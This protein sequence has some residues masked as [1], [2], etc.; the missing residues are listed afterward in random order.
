MGSDGNS[1]RPRWPAG[2]GRDS[3]ARQMARDEKLNDLELPKNN[4]IL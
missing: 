1:R 4:R 3:G 2:A